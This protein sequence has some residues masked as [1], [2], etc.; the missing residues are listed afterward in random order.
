MVWLPVTVSRKRSVQDAAAKAFYDSIIT[1]TCTRC[2][3]Q[4]HLHMAVHYTDLYKM[5]AATPPRY[6]SIITQTYTRCMQQH[7]LH[8]AVALH[9]RVQD[10]CS[11]TTYIWQYHYTDV[12]KMHAATPPTYGSIITQTCTRCMQQHH[13]HMAVALHRHVQDAATKTFCDSVIAQMQ[14]QKLPMT[15]IARM[16]QQKLPMTVSLH[17]CSSKSCL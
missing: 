4:H 14:Q 12:Y 2:M 1:Q 11:N 9:R 15:V 17:R 3:Q 13:L 10:A 6:G 8:M 7:H 16:Q 5:H